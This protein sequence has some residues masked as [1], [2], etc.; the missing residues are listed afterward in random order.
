MTGLQSAYVAAVLE[1]FGQP[2]QPMQGAVQVELGSEQQGVVIRLCGQLE[3]GN[4]E[5]MGFRVWG[6]PHIIAAT[7]LA[8]ERLAGRPVSALARPAVAA[9]L[10]EQRELLDIPAEKAGK[11]LILMDALVELGAAL[12]AVQSS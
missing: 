4:I 2:P 9:S 10:A 11:I 6:C 7:A 5:H 8:T 3:D 12:E 1:Y